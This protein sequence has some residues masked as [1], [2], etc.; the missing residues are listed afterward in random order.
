M[1]LFVWLNLDGKD[2]AVF[3]V[4]DLIG[5]LAAIWLYPVNATLAGFVFMLVPYH[6]FLAWLVFDADRSG[7][8]MPIFSTILTHLASI[9]LVVCIQWEHRLIPF[10]GVV[11]YAI[12]ASAVFERSWLFSGSSVKREKKRPVTAEAAATAAAAT[13]AADEAT[14][15]DYEEW[16]RY[17]AQPHRPTR[18]PGLSLKDEYG[19]WLV[20]RAK[21]RPAASSNEDTA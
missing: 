20:A 17:I 18:K 1:G 12:P 7:L 6:L 15:G 9:A 5:L 3:V 8:S 13:K 2:F 21:G 19:Q 4:S 14:A 16:L 11:K 10:F